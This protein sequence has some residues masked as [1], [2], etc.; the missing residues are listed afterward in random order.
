MIKYLSKVR[1]LAGKF[2]NFE[3]IRI[4]RIE[5]TKADVLSKLVASGYTTLGSICMEFLKE[6]SIENEAVEVM[7]VEHEPCWMNEIIEYLRSGKLLEAK[8]EAYKVIQRATR[9]SLDG[10]S[11]YKRSY[12]LPYLKCLRP[13][14][15]AYTLQEMHE[16]IYGEHLGGKPLAIKVLLRGMYWPTLR[17]DAL[18]LVRRCERCQKFSPTIHQPTISMAPITSPLPFAVW[19]MD[20]LGP[21]PPASGRR[22]FVVVAIDYFTKWVE[23]EPLA[24]ITEQN[25]QTFFWKSVVYRFGVS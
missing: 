2:K 21:F 13:S 7:Q 1:R 16:G 3:V 15:A 17:Q 24:Q 14:D 4:P 20:I 12:T 9:F 19:G 11:M 25:V 10:E 5:N 18:E 22:E 23:A 8:K 6:S